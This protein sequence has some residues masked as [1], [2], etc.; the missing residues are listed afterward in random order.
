MNNTFRKKPS[1]P[2]GAAALSKATSAA[3]VG[4]AAVPPATL[5][6]LLTDTLA[7]GMDLREIF[8][9]LRRRVRLILGFALSGVIISLLAAFLTTPYY[10]AETVL[11]LDQRR[12]AA[13]DFGGVV[14]PQSEG[15][16]LLRSQIDIITSRAVLDRVTKKLE[17]TKD[18]DYNLK[19]FW[20]RFFSK[21]P[22]TDTLSDAERDGR[23]MTRVAEAL[24]KHLDVSNDGRSYSIRI[25][26]ESPSPEKAARLANAIADE[27]L[28]DQL[29]AKYELAAR[30]NKWLNERLSSLRQDVEGSERAVE[31]FRQKA[32]LI[33]VGGSTVA[34]RQMDEINR[35]LTEA[36]GQTSQAEARLRSAQS[37]VRSE[38]GFEAAA[39]VLNSPLIQRLR[40]Q[41]A[42]VRRK[43][44]ELATHY[45]DRH[46]KMINAKAEYQDL[47]RKIGEEVKKIMQGMANEVDIA[48][49]KEQQL[50]RDMDTL[51]AR[52]GVDLKNS[53]QLHQ[54]QREAEA[55]KTLYESFLG[56]FKQS[57]E[58]QDMQLADSRIIAPAEVPLSPTSPKKTL[59]VGIGALLGLLAGLFAA[60]LVEYFDCGYRNSSQMETDTGLPAVGLVPSLKGITSKTPEAYVIEKPLSAF[61]ESLR[62]V[63]TAIHF[64]NVDHPPKV[65]M[66]TSSM[67][68]EGKTTFCLSLGR[69]LALAGNK[70]LVIDADMRCPRV[71]SAM[72][73]A[74]K[75]KGGLAD[76]LAGRLQIADVLQHDP[77]V[78]G[79]SFLPSRDKTPNAQDL[80]GS[81][82]MQRLV[83]QAAA[84]YDLVIIDTPPILAVTDAAMVARVVDT[85]LLV[86]R[87]AETPRETV[88]QAVR[89]LA[90]YGC[91]VAGIVMSQVDL[92]RQASYGDGS[93]HKEYS[94]YYT[95]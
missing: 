82:R 66:L 57:T 76:V 86:V 94:A 50:K 69:V 95:D 27:Y 87:W 47:Q 32:R 38:G 75:I 35:Q 8:L 90:S 28:V 33:E 78:R 54:L 88:Q 45:G 53:V 9:L 68:K 46:P 55:N 29:E 59:Y 79:L 15:N 36:R 43:E 61:A 19:P 10:R 31:N 58:Q 7:G 20:G 13:T 22:A 26:F 91:K 92:D 39:D 70:V 49:A 5:S 12:A 84:H 62:T 18:T 73:V 48:R 51:E 60:Y 3:T 11:M 1:L 25:A 4:V 2:H 16:T 41:E 44:A 63:R 42:E 64:S 77:K 80:L 74:S 93:Y 56:R 21:A 40:E 24:M 89:R 72:G 81:Q 67:P 34:S 37:M 65:V 85:T 83:Q 71:A 14:A 30:A 6:A 17:L 23:E 52:A